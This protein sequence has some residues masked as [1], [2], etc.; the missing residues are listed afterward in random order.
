MGRKENNASKTLLASLYDSEKSSGE[1]HGNDV[2]GQ[3]THRLNKEGVDQG[4]RGTASFNKEPKFHSND[5]GVKP[6][7]YLGRNVPPTTSTKRPRKGRNDQTNKRP[8]SSNPGP[9]KNEA[10]S[11]KILAPPKRNGKPFKAGKSEPLESIAQH[12]IEEENPRF[13]PSHETMPDTKAPQGKSGES[14]RTD[15]GKDSSSNVCG[16][17]GLP[18]FSGAG[19]VTPK[20]EM[21]G[22]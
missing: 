19:G 6:R 9:S 7:P 21:H 17:T 2:Q 1:S 5:N 11:K 15:S 22:M 13:E 16:T 3:L 18:K 4:S 8:G 20:E 10:Q 12:Q 14:P